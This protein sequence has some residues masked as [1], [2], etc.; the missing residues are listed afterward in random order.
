MGALLWVFMAVMNGKGKQWAGIVA[1]VLFGISVLFTLGSLVQEAP[2][3]SR[4]LSLVSLVL[5][6]YIVFLLFR[7]D[8]TQYYD[9]QS[10]PRV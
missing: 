5:G 6:G 8:S 10:A 7:P 3:L 4:I 9:A 2:A 1:T